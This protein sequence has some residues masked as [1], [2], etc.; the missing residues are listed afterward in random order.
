MGLQI[1]VKMYS[2]RGKIP[3]NLV[4]ALK[5]KLQQQVEHKADGIRDKEYSTLTTQSSC[6]TSEA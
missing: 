4:T 2:A 3:R 1:A 5:R 6:L